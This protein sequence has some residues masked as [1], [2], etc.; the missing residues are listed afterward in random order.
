[1]V[2]CDDQT[3][4]VLI[5]SNLPIFMLRAFCVLVKKLL[6]LL[7]LFYQGHKDI[8]IGLLIEFLLFYSSHLNL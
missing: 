7:L 6:L 4:L 1:M 3:V 8:P 2:F 5:K